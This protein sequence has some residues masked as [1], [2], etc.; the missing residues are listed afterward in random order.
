MGQ[1][2]LRGRACTD[3]CLRNFSMPER[4]DK[5][6]TGDVL[7][8]PTFRAKLNRLVDYC[9]SL[10]PHGDGQTVKVNR[11][12]G[13]SF[14]SAKAGRGGGAGGLVPVKRFY[15]FLN[16]TFSSTSINIPS[17]VIENAA[18]TFYNFA[19]GYTATFTGA[20]G[21]IWWDAVNDEW[22]DTGGTGKILFIAWRDDSTLYRPYEVFSGVRVNPVAAWENLWARLTLRQQIYES[23]LSGIPKIEIVNVSGSGRSILIHSPFGKDGFNNIE[24]ISV[25]NNSFEDSEFFVGKIIRTTLSPPDNADFT[26]YYETTA[27]AGIGFNYMVNFSLSPPS[28]YIPGSSDVVSRG[29]LLTGKKWGGHIIRISRISG[30][31]SR[32]NYPCFVRL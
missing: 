30:I 17:C 16:V 5:F 1:P 15:E 11:I 10:E 32:M 23:L 29:I 24:F 14:F 26:I 6:S 18:N 3:N 9:R 22:T 21:G 8:E 19:A 27:S 7:T 12:P 28:G 25:V 13:G 4:P 20:A 31:L 2:D